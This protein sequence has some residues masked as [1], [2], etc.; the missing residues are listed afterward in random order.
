MKCD[1]YLC[2]IWYLNMV[3]LYLGETSSYHC[4]SQCYLFKTYK[5]S[6]SVAATNTC[7]TLLELRI[8]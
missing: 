5:I 8:N 4:V 1:F 3:A 2:N 7:T 6:L